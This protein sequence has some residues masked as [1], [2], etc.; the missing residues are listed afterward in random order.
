MPELYLFSVSWAVVVPVV[1][2]WWIGWLWCVPLWHEYKTGK[3]WENA[4]H[5]IYIAVVGWGGVEY[6]RLDGWAYVVCAGGI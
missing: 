6:S 3:G 1:S 2:D 4:F 5:A